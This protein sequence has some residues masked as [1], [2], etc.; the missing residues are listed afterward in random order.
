MTCLFRQKS[1][2]DNMCRSCKDRGQETLHPG[3]GSTA[4]SCH[5]AL[6]NF[7]GKMLPRALATSCGRKI[8][9]HAALSAQCR[10]TTCSLFSDLTNPADDI[11]T[12]VRRPSVGLQKQEQSLMKLRPTFGGCRGVNG[13]GQISTLDHLAWCSIEMSDL[14]RISTHCVLLPVLHSS[15]FISAEQSRPEF[16][17]V[18]QHTYYAFAAS[19]IAHMVLLCERYTGT[20]LH[21]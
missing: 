7:S 12:A 11:K 2:K 17:L 1:S 14:T 5:L 9:N 4:C 19:S 10:H 3:N 6:R 13:K 20:G 18:L 15:P 8:P 21:T 16:A